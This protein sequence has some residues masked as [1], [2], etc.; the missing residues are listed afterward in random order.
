MTTAQSSVAQDSYEG[1][2]LV[3]MPSMTDRRFA[4]S[5]VYLCAHSE[6]GAMGL[7]INQRARHIS[8][9]D[10]LDKLG[11]YAPDDTAPLSQ[12]PIQI[13]GPVETGRGFVLHSP[14]FV[15]EDSTMPIDPAVSLT[16]TVDIL[17]AIIEGR[18]PSRAILALGYAG[19]S[20]GQLENEIQ[21]NGWLTC[22]ADP[23]IIFDDNTES[24]YQ[25][26]LAQL[27]IDLSHLVSDAGHC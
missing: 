16:A 7:I 1:Q 12:L 2:F 8:P 20:P 19:W 3:A 25:R 24:K 9:P 14:D 27:G 4:R 11:I 21:A 5:V 17:K 23:E 10:L 18:G 15:I 13:G 6:D 22:P 26:A